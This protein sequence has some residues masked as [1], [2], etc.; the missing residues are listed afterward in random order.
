MQIHDGLRNPRTYRSAMLSVEILREENQRYAA[1]LGISQN[2]ACLGFRP[3]Y[4]NQKSGEWVLSRFRDGTPAPIH[5][6]DGLPDAWV[7]ARDALGHVIAVDASVISGFVRDG[8]FYTREEAAR[9][10]RH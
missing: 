6:L 10:A 8:R 4:L 3:A 7:R 9:Q 5:I 1:S 2:N